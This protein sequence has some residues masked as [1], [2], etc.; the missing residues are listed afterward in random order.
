MPVRLPFSVYPRFP[1][2]CPSLHA[3]R[4]RPSNFSPLFLNFVPP[5]HKVSSPTLPFP[6]P[7]PRRYE[8]S[9]NIYDGDSPPPPP[10]PLP[11]TRSKT[12][13]NRGMHKNHPHLEFD[14]THHAIASCINLATIIFESSKYRWNGEETGFQLKGK[15]LVKSRERP[16]FFNFAILESGHEIYNLRVTISDDTKECDTSP[17]FVALSHPYRSN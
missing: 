5:L 13:R 15:F 3:Y 14:A 2:S 9:M 7:T 1:R 12:W 6:T 17:P 10:S 8:I 11:S 4:T 16:S